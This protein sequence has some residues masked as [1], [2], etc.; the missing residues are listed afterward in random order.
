MRAKGAASPMYQLPLDQVTVTLTEGS[1]RFR[2]ADG[3]AHEE[4]WAGGSPRA[5]WI[6]FK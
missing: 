2:S 1:V 4:E 6:E 5:I 3:A